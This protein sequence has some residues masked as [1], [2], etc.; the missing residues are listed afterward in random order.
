MAES[1]EKVPGKYT[2]TPAMERISG[3]FCLEKRA[4]AGVCVFALRAAQRA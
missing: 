2:Q 4:F 3:R 1:V